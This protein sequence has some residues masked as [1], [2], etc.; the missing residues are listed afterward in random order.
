MNWSKYQDDI[1]DAYRFEDCNIAVMAGP[2]SGKTTL[3]KQLCKLTPLTERSIFLAF[4]KSIVEELAN[5]LPSSVEVST[6]HS[7]GCK[8]IYREYGNVKVV[9]S[10][11]FGFLKKL[12]H[13][14]K[15]DLKDI[16]NVN[17]YLYNI[18]QLYDLY[19]MNL[20]GGVG[21]ELVKLSNLHGL[22]TSP[23]ILEHLETLISS[24]TKVN[25][26]SRGIYTIDYIDMIYLPLV[27][28]M[29]FPKYD[30]VFLD[31]AQDLNYCQHQ[32]VNKILSRSSRLIV[33]GD[34]NQCIY[35]FL[36]ADPESFQS[37]TSR[38]NTKTLPLSIS[39]RCPKNV[40]DKVNTVYDVVEAAPD[41]I[42]G[43][44][45]EGDIDEVDMGDMVLCRNNKPLLKAY[46]SLLDEEKKA[47]VRGAEFG[48]GIIRM[49]SP[50]KI[51]NV[52]FCISNLYND[53]ERIGFDL[54]SKGIHN[55]TAHPTYIRFEENIE[56]I[57][58]I[59]TRYDQV[60][61]ALPI[62]ENIFKNDGEGIMLSTIHKAKGLEAD[63]V[64]LL[65]PELIPSKFAYQKWEID[66]EK[67]LLFVAYSRA[68]KELIFIRNF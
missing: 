1:F 46:F 54:S 59:A 19:R 21:E 16:N 41:A 27:Q 67:K 35:A 38:L 45:R 26:I 33:V 11:T 65:N 24:M 18:S 50:Y 68:K 40:V 60:S 39:Y 51:N 20:L 42:D 55:P 28:N 7:L 52:Q 22:E 32:L 15:D 17:Y 31:E 36:G 10:K 44:V 3:L 34:P 58:I 30:R 53:L 48:N 43:V 8:A 13:K 61:E 5:S 47:Y 23:K 12:E 9:E 63:R 62:I 56:L 37:F 66:Q 29:N 57:K 2:G 64:F 4:N 25:R 14:W 49:L 6:L